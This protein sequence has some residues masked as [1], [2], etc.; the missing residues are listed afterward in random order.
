M[1]ARSAAA[2]DVEK[3][4]QRLLKIVDQEW[5]EE[6]AKL[7]R[8]VAELGRGSTGRRLAKD[9]STITNPVGAR[10]LGA[11]GAARRVTQGRFTTIE[12]AARTLAQTHSRV[13][14]DVSDALLQEIGDALGA[15]SEEAFVRALEQAKS[16]IASAFAARIR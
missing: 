7:K 6:C 5:R 8:W 14:Q 9:A 2:D 11:A 12:A 13:P 16:K 4:V 1:K 3:R 10:I 15:S